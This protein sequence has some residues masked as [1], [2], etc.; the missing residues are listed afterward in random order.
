MERAEVGG[1]GGVL[2]TGECLLLLMFQ[3]EWKH[4]AEQRITQ[5]HT[6]IPPRT[7]THTHTLLG[8]TVWGS[9]NVI[10]TMTLSVSRR[11]L[12]H[13]ASAH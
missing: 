13:C 11:V 9:E 4:K 6:H 2:G 10:S 3:Q 7:H 1:G 8:E 12:S 5:T